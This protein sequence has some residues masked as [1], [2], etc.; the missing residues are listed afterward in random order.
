MTDGA[1]TD[2]LVGDTWQQLLKRRSFI[3]LDA[4]GRVGALLDADSV[5][6][7]VGPFDRLESPWLEP[8]GIVPQADD[9]VVLARGTVG[10][11]PVVVAAIEQ[12]FQG[13]ATGEVSGAK[14]SQALLLAA[15]DA[16]A[17]NPTAAV[18]L[19]ETGGVRLQEANLGLNAV[20][21]IC[22]AVLDLRPLAP[23]IGIVA[24]TVGSF[25]G[26]SIAAGLCTKLIVTPHA[27]IGLNG[28]AVIE[29]EA[30]VDEFD[31]TDHAQIWAVDGGRQRCLAGLADVL[32]PDDADEIR[33]V[34]ADALR[35]GVPEAGG[36]RSQQLNVMATR[37]A[38]L[39]P[40]ANV[41][42]DTE[43]PITRG[44][45]WLQALA[46]T[47][48]V[49]VIPSVI[50][51]TANDSHY[52]AVVPD[53]HNRFYRA[54][55]GQVGLTESLALAQ[56]VR[57]LMAE[58]Q[59]T[60]RKRAVVAVVDLPSQAYGRHEEAAGL[61]QVMAATTDAYHAARVAGHPVVA[62][63]VGSALSGGF[64]TH[65]LQAQQILALND[66]GVEIHAMH[67]QAAA[68]I[69]RRTVDEL[70]QL[71]ATI[72]PLSYHV[73][74]WAQLGFCDGLLNVENADHPT[75]RDV[76]AVRAALAESVDKARSGPLDLSNRLD[77]KAAAVARR[78]SRA[79]RDHLAAQWNT[80]L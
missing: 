12:G 67:K 2:L 24:G 25:G 57:A 34:L 6:V 80:G 47:D 49:P 10:G 13:G 52:L 62:L 76:E 71:A 23:V 72:L 39:D 58:D 50:A 14:I 18:I 38:A 46:G 41:L 28:P 4:L 31:S 37:L 45:V 70:E 3:E 40:G 55:Q 73:T 48:P 33:R 78:G 8:Q 21:E 9:G 42:A 17:D 36:Y 64:L 30:G 79:V 1:D 22:S 51:A 27:R 7:L 26:M 35:A 59:H 75:P 69:T 43:R 61:H 20:A 68:R 32:V 5:R 15:A 74:D 66:P 63:V 44:Q 11:Q 56:V 29:Q 19:F 65:G 77:S 16:R 53:P 54:R 60:E